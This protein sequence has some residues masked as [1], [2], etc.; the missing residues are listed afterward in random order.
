MST[1]RIACAGAVPR[2]YADAVAR[3]D[4]ETRAAGDTPEPLTWA[5]LRREGDDVEAEALLTH[6]EASAGTVDLSTIPRE[7]IMRALELS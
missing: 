2:R 3:L 1:Y 4:A 6:E 5:A 7:R